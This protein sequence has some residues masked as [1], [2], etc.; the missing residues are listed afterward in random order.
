[1]LFLSKINGIEIKI[2]KTKMTITQKLREYFFLRI[3][4][5][6]NKEEAH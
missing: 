4:G 3:D 5:G 2:L 6:E 1:M